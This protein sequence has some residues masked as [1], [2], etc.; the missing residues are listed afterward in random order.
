MSNP[1][2]PKLLSI[3]PEAPA[4]IGTGHATAFAH[5]MFVDNREDIIIYIGDGAGGLTIVNCSDPTA[6]YILATFKE[7]HAWDME[8]SGSKAYIAHG[9]MG[10]GNPGVMIANMS[11]PE[12][13]SLIFNYTTNYDVTDIEIIGDRAFIVNSDS[14]LIIL[15][16][17]NS[18]APEVLGQYSGGANSYTA[19][20]E[21]WG[22]LVFLIFWENGLKILDI[23]DPANIIEIGE[24]SETYLTTITLDTYSKLGYLASYNDGLVILN[25]T[26]PSSPIEIGRYH[27]SGKVC[28]TFLRNNLIFVADQDEG[29]KILQM[30]FSSHDFIT[31]S[32]HTKPTFSS[33][34]LTTRTESVTS[35]TSS[36]N[37]LLV[38]LSLLIFL[39]SKRRN[40]NH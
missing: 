3:I 39:E 14:G 28:K 37:L 2:K 19:D 34:L 22:D 15:D 8:M 7:G 11:D 33:S 32:F 35:S 36:L 4:V 18:S 20:V 25:L 24:F 31:T 23:A 6:P 38:T 29:L 17:S 16:I 12:N 27:D 30:V 26:D 9:F 40:Q 1:S 10:L 13:P 5:Q 21:I